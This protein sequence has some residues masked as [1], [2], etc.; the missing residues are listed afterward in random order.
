ME[1]TRTPLVRLN[2]AKKK[3]VLGQTEYILVWVSWAEF[4]FG[5]HNILFISLLITIVVLSP[6]ITK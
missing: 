3:M 1:P 2:A 5:T 4:S 6:T